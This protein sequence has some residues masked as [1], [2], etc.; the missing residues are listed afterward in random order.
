LLESE[1]YVLCYLKGRKDYLKLAGIPAVKSYGF[2]GDYNILVM[3]L[4]GKSLEDL[5]QACG[6]KFTLKTV[7]M[8][9]DEMV[10][11]L[12][13]LAQSHRVCPHKTHHTQRH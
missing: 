5:F 1:A 13:K 4:L 6:G 2:S 7:C 3:E 11:D 8:L 12:F 9:G 10:R